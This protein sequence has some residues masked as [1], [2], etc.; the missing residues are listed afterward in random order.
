MQALEDAAAAAVEACTVAEGVV[1]DLVAD[2][3]D[4][5][6][7][8][9]ARWLAPSVPSLDVAALAEAAFG[10]MRSP[11]LVRPV[12]AA[13]S[14]PLAPPHLPWWRGAVAVEAPGP[15][16][17]E[18]HRLGWRDGRL[19]LAAHPDPDAERA[20]AALG[21]DRC[22]CLDVLDAWQAAGTGPR[23]LTAA[24]RHDA[25][26]V[27]APDDAIRELTADLRR[28]RGAVADLLDGARAAADRAATARLQELCGPIERA[29][30]DRLGFLLLLGLDRRLQRRLQGAA[31]DAANR[32]GA[33]AALEVATA[34]RALPALRR[35]GWTGGLASIRLGDEARVDAD[36]AVLPPAWLASVWG[37]GLESVVP[38][39][40]VVDVPEVSGDGRFEV[41]A[42][43][44]GK[45][46]VAVRVDQ[47]ENAR[48]PE[49]PGA[50]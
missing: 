45:A 10:G 40:L 32:S 5:L 15:A 31:A 44:P 28:W 9:G 4:A 41:L 46:Q 21:A 23:I 19:Q 49:I 13:A 25:D 33:T 43:A 35:L 16:G 30:R 8:R 18:D 24:A 7:A 22:P 38:E 34:A 36:A 47:W 27:A 20:L 14:P 11:L 37:R 26:A 17:A 48:A 2:V 12:G 29:A 50:I 42:A 39:R 6:V 1:H 3:A